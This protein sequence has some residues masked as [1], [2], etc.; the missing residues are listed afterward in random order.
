MKEV[1]SPGEIHR[2]N[3]DIAEALSRIGEKDA[4]LQTEDTGMDTKSAQSHLGKHGGFES[5]IV[6]LEAQLQVL[7][8]D[9][10]AL[11]SRYPGEDGQHIAQQQQMVL[12]ARKAALMSSNDYYNFMGMDRDL[13]FWT[14]EKS[15]YLR[16]SIRRCFGSNADHDNLKKPS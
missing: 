2:F 15:D 5:Y 4:I 7:I 6:A 10:A 13:V 8:D 12:R 16:E 3:R 9:S 11:Q 14:V 1:E